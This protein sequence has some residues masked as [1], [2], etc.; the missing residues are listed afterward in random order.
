VTLNTSFREYNIT[1]ALVLLCVYQH[2]TFLMLSFT[3]S[4]DM[5]GAKFKNASRDPITPVRA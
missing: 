3:I 1:R 5:I 4:K 2:T